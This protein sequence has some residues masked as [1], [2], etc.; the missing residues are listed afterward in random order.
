MPT[1]RRAPRGA[2]RQCAPRGVRV[3][4]GGALQPFGCKLQ[5]VVLL[6]DY[7]YELI[8]YFCTFVYFIDLTCIRKY[9]IIGHKSRM[10]Y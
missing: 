3:P 4:R 7:E 1:P 6:V 10:K 9:K 5:R 8:A 2:L